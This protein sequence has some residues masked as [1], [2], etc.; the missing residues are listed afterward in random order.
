MGGFQ[1]VSTHFTMTDSPTDYNPGEQLGDLILK[2]IDAGLAR[3]HAGRP[4][5]PMLITP[6]GDKYDV[7]VFA[8]LS[9]DDAYAAAIRHLGFAERLVDACV[10]IFPATL[11]AE[12]WTRPVRVVAVE[13]SQRGAAHGWRLIGVPKDEGSE[14][15]ALYEGHAPMMMLPAVVGERTTDRYNTE[16]KP[17]SGS[18]RWWPFW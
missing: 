9:V 11:R 6:V 13:G 14:S 16:A 2:G 4:L 12:G 5:L 7:T 8:D 10:F 17:K 3:L 1:L 15:A 18:R